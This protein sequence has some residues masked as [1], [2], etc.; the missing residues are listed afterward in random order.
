MIKELKE[1]EAGAT[2]GPWQA[3]LGN[4][5]I[6]QINPRNEI[7]RFDPNSREVHGIGPR[8]HSYSDMEFICA[9][10]N[11]IKK[12]IAFVE[13]YDFWWDKCSAFDPCDGVEFEKLETAR[14][15]LDE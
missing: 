8:V 5:D 11:K 3:D 14:K 2:P 7:C 1:L 10:R 15:E 13:A 9:M 6:E 12:L 4:W